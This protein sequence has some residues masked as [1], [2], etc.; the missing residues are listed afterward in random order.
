MLEI[1]QEKKTHHLWIERLFIMFNHEGVKTNKGNH[2][3]LFHMSNLKIWSP[4]KYDDK[5]SNMHNSNEFTAS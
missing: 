1:T 2:S 3:I 4:K 5:G